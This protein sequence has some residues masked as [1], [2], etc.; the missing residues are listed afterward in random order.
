MDFA[1]SVDQAID[2]LSRNEF[3]LIVTD[4][5]MPEK[6]GFVLLKHV[7]GNDCFNRQPVVVL[8]GN[9]DIALKSKALEL[10]ASDLLNKPVIAQD[11]IARIKNTLQIKA[12]Q[13]QIKELN[14]DLESKILER[15]FDLEISHIEILWRL[16]KAGE[17]RDEETGNHTTRVGLYS[18]TLSE[19]LDL[20]DDFSNSV[21][22][23]SPLHDIGKIGIPDGILA[24]PGKLTSG[25][26]A[27]M[28]THCKIGAS[29]LQDEVQGIQYYLKTVAHLQDYS[30]KRNYL[31]D[32]ASS[33][34][35][36]HHERW[37]GLG[38]PF[39]LAGPDI[40]L[41]ARIVALADV[42]DALQSERPYKPAFSPEKSLAIIQEEKGRQFDPEIVN[43]FVGF[44]EKFVDIGQELG[45]PPN[46][47][48]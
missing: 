16:A 48:Q 20:P 1:R 11:L 36:H 34:A 29:I 5:N 10:G 43:V 33:I 14:K 45:D 37:D 9:A 17:Y 15:T 32:L 46:S 22:L 12:Y 42:F 2:L 4:V 47:A 41:V 44:F 35:L 23:S 40:P 38:Y 19:L 3:D 6:D 27:I 26:W 18:R 8:T 31:L 7:C 30:Y 28:R 25:E 39:G 13:D 21:F 24:K